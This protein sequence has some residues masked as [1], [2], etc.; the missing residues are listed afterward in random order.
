MAKTATMAKTTTTAKTAVILGLDNQDGAYLARLLLAR[1]YRVRGAAT[2][3]GTAL[4]RLGIA[5]DVTVTDQLDAALFADATEVYDLRGP[6][7][8]RTDDTVRLL[9]LLPEQTRLFS[10]GPGAEA[11]VA[12]I[13]VEAARD[14]GRFAVTGWLFERESRLG[15]GGSP[16]ARIIA[17][18][19]AG[20]DI[21]DADL[22]TATDCGW[23]PEYVDAMW[24]M[25]QR[26]TAADYVLGTGRPLHGVDAARHAFDYFKRSYSRFVASAHA[27]I[28][29]ADTAP[30]RTELGWSATTWGR[31]LVR[32]L[33][34]GLAEQGG[35]WD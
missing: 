27:T 28:A 34:E 15:T 21:A 12:T 31:D 14:R 35:R 17:A 3:G 32:T 8:T 23:A 4:T 19:F 9:D 25:L 16:L 6:G 30:A 26:P 2:Q 1:S 18:A 24:R 29:V 5:D 20:D 33:C 7:T 22:A 10:A 11:D 13:L